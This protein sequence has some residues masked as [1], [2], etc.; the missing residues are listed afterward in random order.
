MIRL[1]LEVWPGEMLAMPMMG[2]ARSVGWQSKDTVATHTAQTL[3]KPWSNHPSYTE[4]LAEAHWNH[5]AWARALLADRPPV[6]GNHHVSRFPSVGTFHYRPVAANTQA[7][8]RI[9]AARQAAWDERNLTLGKRPGL[10]RF[11]EKAMRRARGR[12][13][14]LPSR[15]APSL[16]ISPH[17]L[18]AVRQVLE[19]H[20][21]LPK[22]LRARERRALLRKLSAA[23]AKHLTETA[24]RESSIHHDDTIGST[25][26]REHQVPGVPSRPNGR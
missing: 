5:M 15:T 1:L 26:Q 9:G 19:A 24:G 11:P 20:G 23:A 8:S 22:K 17:I 25:L 14:S 2:R 6:T 13:T 12:S 10:P 4:R 3:A 18:D 21:P 16:T 7:A